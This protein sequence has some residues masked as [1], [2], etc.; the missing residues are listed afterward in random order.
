[1]SRSSCWLLLFIFVS[2]ANLSTVDFLVY[3]VDIDFNGYSGPRIDPCGT[4][5]DTAVRSDVSADHHS[6]TSFSQPRLNHDDTW[7]LTRSAFNLTSSLAW[8][9]IECLREVD[10]A[11]TVLF[12][13]ILCLRHPLLVQ[14]IP[15]GLTDKT[16]LIGIHTGYAWST[17]C[18][19]N[20]SW[21]DPRLSAQVACQYVTSDWFVGSWGPRV[22]SLSWRLGR[23]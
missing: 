7:S 10:E 1:M 3:I 2:S 23:H 11:T 22:C 19:L 5:L 12:P 16:S 17:V 8:D 13:L 6:L 4:P 9:T 20:V 14:W 15:A 21:C 18:C